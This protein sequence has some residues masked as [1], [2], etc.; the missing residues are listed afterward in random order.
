MTWRTVLV[1]AL[2]LNA[3]LVFA[4]RLYRLAR[5]GPVADAVGGAVLAIIVSTCGA[6]LVA[7]SGWPRWPALLYAGVFALLVM[8]FWTL[9]VLIPLPP[10]RVDIAF[11]GL[12]WISLVAI[13]VAAVAL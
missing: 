6:F 9:A 3:A 2:F 7:G 5:G 1:V 8:P 12:Y 11:T 10:E 4:Y 13:G